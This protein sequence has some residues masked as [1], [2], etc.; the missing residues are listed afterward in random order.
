MGTPESVRSSYPCSALRHPI[1]VEA[2]G[3]EWQQSGDR[4]CRKVRIYLVCCRTFRIHGLI[5]WVYTF[6]I[7][8]KSRMIVP[9]FHLPPCGE[10]EIA[11]AISGG[12]PTRRARC[13]AR[14]DL[15]TRGRWI[16]RTR[17]DFA[18]FR[19]VVCLAFR[20]GIAESRSQQRRNA[21]AR[22]GR[23]FRALF[24][25]LLAGTYPLPLRSTGTRGCCPS[26]ARPRP[27]RLRGLRWPT[28]SGLPRL[29]VSLR[30]PHASWRRRRPLRDLW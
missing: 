26:V 7:I 27:M 30:L 6:V 22:D 3:C 13:A 14:V 21:R 24:L 1:N 2:R 20:R 17:I 5:N 15:P 28:A 10:V 16:V 23:N 11:S 29:R 19:P 18:L 9:A 8:P 25:A 4:C 12:G